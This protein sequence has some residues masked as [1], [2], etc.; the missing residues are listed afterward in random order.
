[1][2]RGLK[3]ILMLL[4]LVGL[5][6]VNKQPAWACSCVVPGSP[7]EEMSRVSAVLAGRVLQID[8]PFGA[9]GN[10]AD[11]VR[12]TL[13]VQTVW[14]GPTDSV[15]AV[16]TSQHSASCGYSFVE[17]E[18]YLIYAFAQ[19]GILQVSLCSRTVPLAHAG[20]DLTALGPGMAVQPEEPSAAPNGGSSPLLLVAAALAAVTVVIVLVSIARRR[21]A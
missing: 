8:T 19:E 5:L 12:V 21:A 2:K 20:E 18:E 3:A 1:M 14:K 10:T 16:I 11:S 13:Q 17:G 9:V 4:A 7:Q 15:Q 6:V